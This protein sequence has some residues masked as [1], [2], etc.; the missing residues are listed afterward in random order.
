MP[1]LHS[2]PL[3]VVVLCAGCTSVAPLDVRVIDIRPVQGEHGSL[4]QRFDVGLRIV[5]PNDKPFSA[6]GL[7]LDLEVNGQPLATGVS[8]APIEIPRLG[9]AVA[10]VTVGTTLFDLARQVLALNQ[11]R[12]E[13]TYGITGRIY[14]GGLHLPIR[15]EKTGVLPGTTQTKP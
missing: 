2:W 13:M 10:T 5:N 11:R 1:H 8:S 14:R 6:T 3:L 12:P 4:E 9:E 7:S 15:F